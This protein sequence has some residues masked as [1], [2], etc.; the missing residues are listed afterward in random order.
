ML[1]DVGEFIYFFLK[2]I[3]CY[4]IMYDRS[5]HEFIEGMESF[6]ERREIYDIKDL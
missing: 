5:S 6:Q 2:I 1:S 3:L 4:S